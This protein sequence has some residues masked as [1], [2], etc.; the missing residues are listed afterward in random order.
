[1]GSM[2][3]NK[4]LILIETILLLL[5]TDI[6]YAQ[7]SGD[8]PIEFRPGSELLS[9]RYGNNAQEV[10]A[11]KQLV[12]HYEDVI[13][14]GNGHLRLVAPIGS[15]EEA[16]QKEINLSALRA[17]AVRNLI[18]KN[19][20]MFTN[21]NFTFY[22]DD[23]RPYN[24]T[25][26]VCYMPYA[27]PQ[28]VP[29]NM[30]ETPY[31]STAPPFS[32]DATTRAHF[33]KINAIATNPIDVEAK[34]GEANPEKLLIAIHYRWDKY[35]LD[36]LYL[37]NP[38][39]LHLLDSV[40]NSRNSKYIDTLTIVAYASP[41]GD[42]T[43]NKRLSERRAQTIKD[44]I[45]NKYKMIVSDR[46]ITEARGENW[47][48]LRNFAVRDSALPS[49]SEVLRIIDSSLPSQQKQAQLTKLDNGVTYYRYIQPNY[50]R[51]LRNG[52]SVVI[53]YS[54]D[55]PKETVPDLM[56]EPGIGL[57]PVRQPKLTADPQPIPIPTLIVRYPVAFRT[58][59]L[60]DMIGALNIGVEVPVKKH[61]SFLA[62]F[63][64]SYWRTRKNLYALQTLEGGI[65][66]RYWFGVS[67]KKKKK[68][69]EWAKPLRGWNVGLYGMY[70]SRYDI[71]W[72]DGY[73]GDG[74]WS[75]GLSVGYATPVARNLTLEFSLAGGYFYTPEYR[76]YHR[77]EYDA[78][79]K[80]HLMWQQ[81]GTLGI[82]TLTKARISLVWV[83]PDTKKG[84]KR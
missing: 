5:C 38:D 40:L 31:L 41:E 78:N 30:Y 11:L 58:N 36:S 14:T 43:Y 20:R 28:S 15:N 68:N 51:Y 48:G 52:A 4:M 24:N 84:G 57:L 80:Y 12:S 63:A 61:F 82:F 37:S 81:T 18:R 34:E 1:M 25:I 26:E 23:T 45:V 50:Y 13:F 35:K 42:P 17:V 33:D 83:I 72:K 32:D 46:I 74:Y 21:W 49:R 7:Q 19:F 3:R 71:Q 67:E 47:N 2:E 53:T 62:D 76:H 60:F 75:A 73:Q 55:L 56:P 65:E 70:C 22:L 44:Y 9:D 10:A 6:V 29:S 59:L 64:Y 54:P 79:G 77:P 69:P 16:N 39:N 8:Y 66:G 27:I